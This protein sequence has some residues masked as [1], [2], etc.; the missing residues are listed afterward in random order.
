MRDKVLASMALSNSVSLNIYEIE[1]G[2]DDYVYA[3]MGGVSNNKVRKYKLYYNSKGAYF[4]F[5]KSRYYMNEFI[6]V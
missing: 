4:N 6:R 2:I 1:H 5:G 3:G